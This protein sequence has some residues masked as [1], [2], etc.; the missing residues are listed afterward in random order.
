[1]NHQIMARALIASISSSVIYIQQ[2]VWNLA[3]DVRGLMLRSE[4]D[5]QTRSSGFGS[6]RRLLTAI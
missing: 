3:C 6:A 5:L 4:N 2:G 1:V